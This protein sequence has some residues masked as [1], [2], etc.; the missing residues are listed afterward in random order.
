MNRCWKLSAALIAAG[1]IA[2]GGAR[3]MQADGKSGSAPATPAA[4]NSP[5]GFTGGFLCRFY[6]TDRAKSVR[7]YR[8]VLGFEILFE[9][10]EIGWSELVNREAKLTIGLSQETEAKAGGGVAPVVGVRDIDAARAHL[11]SKGVAFNGPT[12]TIDG[13]VKL[14]SFNDP[15]GHRWTM[16]QSLS[17]E[18]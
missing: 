1:T 7:W 16:Y 3:A 13:L 6:V 9:V 5:L 15:D 11:E 14:A 8:D 2:L 17:A 10:E 12:Q 4:S 18:E